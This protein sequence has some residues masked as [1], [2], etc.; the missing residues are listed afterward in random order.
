M[1]WA[2]KIARVHARASVVAH[3]SVQAVDSAFAG[4]LDAALSDE[5]KTRLGVDLYD[6]AP[7]YREAGQLHAWEERWFDGAL[8]APPARILVGG[9]GAG[10]ELG[11]LLERGYHVDGFE[12]A[13]TLLDSA[14]NR[15]PAA[16][17]WQDTYESWTDALGLAP[18]QRYEAIVLGWGSLSHVIDPSARVALMEAAAAACP[19]GPILA[20]Y[21]ART[22]SPEAARARRV[23]AWLGERLGRGTPSGDA[24]LPNT[25]FVHMFDPDELRALARAVG[26]EARVEGAPGDYPHV[27]FV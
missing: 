16:Q 27:T 18:A 25:G 5:D 12:P 13:A 19:D 23:G 9:C 10:R 20:S 22:S 17:L 24:Y 2:A 8:P 4:F 26:R 3:R 11:P 14:R 21:W 1:S 15:H 6:N 7:H